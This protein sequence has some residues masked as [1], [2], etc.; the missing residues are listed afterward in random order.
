MNRDQER[1]KAEQDAIRVIINRE[2]Q[3]FVTELERDLSHDIA[4]L[5][6]LNYNRTNGKWQA[7]MV[8]NDVE[9]TIE[10]YTANAHFWELRSD[11]KMHRV[12]TAYKDE[13]LPKGWT[14]EE[15][16]DRLLIAIAELSALPTAQEEQTND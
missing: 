2:R 9:I 13:A 10:R 8:R 14:R 16:R 12:Q 15:V 11:T 7:L 6:G 1:E 3:Q 5:C 4:A